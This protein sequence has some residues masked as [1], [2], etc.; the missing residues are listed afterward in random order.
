MSSAQ[1]G[2][3]LEKSRLKEP[4]P[5][6]NSNEIDLITRCF[7]DP[8][9]SR[10]GLEKKFEFYRPW[11]MRPGGVSLLSHSSHSSCSSACPPL[12]RINLMWLMSKHFNA[13]A[14]SPRFTMYLSEAA[15]CVIKNSFYVVKILLELSHPF[16]LGQL[17]GR[18]SDNVIKLRRFTI[19]WS[20]F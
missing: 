10:K 20:G 4:S 14:Y 11:L 3:G 2:G 17:G 8:A 15:T 9:G 16:Q 13:I 19:W 5:R 12:K 7:L 1:S 18:K 6:R